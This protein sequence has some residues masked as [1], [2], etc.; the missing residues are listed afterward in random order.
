MILLQLYIEDETSSSLYNN[1]F[2]LQYCVTFSLLK[3][4]LELVLCNFFLQYFFGTSGLGP[5]CFYSITE[6]YSTIYTTLGISA[7]RFMS[8]CIYRYK[9]IYKTMSSLIMRAMACLL[10]WDIS[11]FHMILTCTVLVVNMEQDVHNSGYV[12]YAVILSRS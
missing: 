6:K 12:D 8:K 10:Y 9:T 7:M 2:Y 11:I 3:Y 1:I 4:K 5:F